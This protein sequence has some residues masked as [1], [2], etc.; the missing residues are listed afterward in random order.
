LN[1]EICSNVEDIVEQDSYEKPTDSDFERELEED[2]RFI[3]E[4]DLFIKEQD[5]ISKK[6]EESI[7]RTFKQLDGLY[8]EI[9]NRQPSII[10]N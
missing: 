2:R 8:Q 7:R 9:K 4:M 3:E 6:N 5:E 1:C 10:K